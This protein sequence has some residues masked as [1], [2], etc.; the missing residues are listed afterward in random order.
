L[1]S[2]A[3]VDFIRESLPSLDRYMV[4]VDSNIEKLNIY[5]NDLMNSLDARGKTDDGITSKLYKGFKSCQDKSFVAY[6]K[7]KQATT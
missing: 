1:D 3:T 7:H 2:D 6:I 5:V 4:K